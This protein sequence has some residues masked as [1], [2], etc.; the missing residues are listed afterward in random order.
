M[1]ADRA[2]ELRKLARQ[3]RARHFLPNA[4]LLEAAA[5][6]IEELASYINAQAEID[7]ARSESAYDRLGLIVDLIDSGNLIAA[8]NMAECLRASIAVRNRRRADA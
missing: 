2:N 7:K 4:E 6:Q 3:Q 5:E 8:R 1:N